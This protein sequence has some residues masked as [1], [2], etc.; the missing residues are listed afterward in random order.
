M[1]AA[2]A[3]RETVKSRRE[4]SVKVRPASDRQTGGNPRLPT[5]RLLQLATGLALLLAITASAAQLTWLVFDLNHK[6]Y[7]EGPILAMVERMRSEE[8]SAAWMNQPPYTL[9]CYGP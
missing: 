9:S 7:G 6:S 8:I 5:L 2:I 4:L 1:D 3:I